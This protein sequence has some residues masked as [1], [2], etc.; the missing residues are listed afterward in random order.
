M[1][2]PP[3]SAGTTRESRTDLAPL[4]ED[5]RRVVPADVDRRVGERQRL[6]CHTPS[7]AGVVTPT[8][9]RTYTQTHTYRQTHNHVSVCCR[10]N[11]ATAI[12]SMY[13]APIF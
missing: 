9:T 12:D 13:D 1:A 3:D 5:T 4:A 6:G 10:R 8:Q 7:Y 11:Y 2:E